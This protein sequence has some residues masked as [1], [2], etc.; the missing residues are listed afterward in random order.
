MGGGDVGALKKA[1]ASTQI[2]NLGGVLS[3][4][5]EGS[6]KGLILNNKSELGAAA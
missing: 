5:G 3:S 2:Y 1:V 6:G 4:I